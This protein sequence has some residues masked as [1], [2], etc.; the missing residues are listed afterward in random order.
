MSGDGSDEPRWLSAEEEMA[1]RTVMILLLQLPTR[2]DAQLLHDSGLTMFDYIVLSSLSMHPGRR[3]R[4]SELATLTNSSP[5][6]LSNVVKRL[7]AQ[8]WVRRAPDPDDGRSTVASLTAS[9]MR[10]VERAAPGHVA[11]VRRHVIDALSPAQ[12][13]TFARAYEPLRRAITPDC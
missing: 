12:V 7:E 2:L 10:V 13:R 9:G 6:R 4:M 3:L 11:A 8:G 1:W 5:S